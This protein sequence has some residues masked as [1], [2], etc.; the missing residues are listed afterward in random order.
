GCIAIGS[1]AKTGSFEG[2]N[3]AIGQGAIAYFERSIAIGSGAEAR[4][5]NAVA[6]GPGAIAN[7]IN[8]IVIGTPDHVVIIPGQLR[9]LGL[10]STITWMAPS[11]N[12]IQEITSPIHANDGITQRTLILRNPGRYRIK[13]Q[14]FADVNS[15]AKLD[16][17]VNDEPIVEPV[18]VSESSANFSVDFTRDIG[19]N[20]TVVF[21]LEVDRISGD[22]PIP[23]A[24]RVGPIQICG[25]E[26]DIGSGVIGW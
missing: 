7:E 19:V 16:I 26:A 2:G 4:A 13:G 24:G 18:F 25:T 20:T 15:W 5:N 9:T 23:S 1:G 8:T 6:L 14:I 10:K 22:E 11:D 17:L 3:I 12:I 21:R